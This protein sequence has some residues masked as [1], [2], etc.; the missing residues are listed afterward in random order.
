MTSDTSNDA[1]PVAAAGLEEAAAPFDAERVAALGMTA[2]GAGP[3]GA[4]RDARRGI[5]DRLRRGCGP[6]LGLSWMSAAER[7]GAETEAGQL[8][9]CF[10]QS[11]ALIAMV[12]GEAHRLAI[13]NPR[14][15][16][17]FGDRPWRDRP[18]AEL[19]PELARNG[20]I[21]AYDR[22]YETGAGEILP[23]IPLAGEVAGE[24]RYFT[25]LLQPRRDDAGRVTGVITLAF[26][27]TE[28]V[29]ARRRAEA[30]AIDQSLQQTS[31]DLA[32]AVGGMGYVAIDLAARRIDGGPLL[33]RLLGAPDKSGGWPLDSLLRALED[34]DAGRLR[35]MLETVQDGA[36]P[37][38]AELSLADHE[39]VVA[40]RLVGRLQRTPA[41]VLIGIVADITERRRS[42][43]LLNRRAADLAAAN[44]QLEQFT[45]LVS[46]DLKSPLRGVHHLA[47]F[48]REDL[49][50]SASP[51][52][53]GHLD[54][55]ERQIAKMSR[56]L[57]DLQAY[58]HADRAAGR[59][60]MVDIGALV[61]ELAELLGVPDTIRLEVDATP[62]RVTTDRT[63]LALVLRNLI[64]NAVKHHDR[65]NG[66]IAVRARRDGR[67]RLRVVVIDDG[68]GIAAK[69]RDAVFE[70]FRSAGGKGAGSGM[71]LAFVR[72]AVLRHGGRIWIEDAPDGFAEPG[73]GVAFT[74]TWPLPLE[75]SGGRRAK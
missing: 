57:D 73:R 14:M 21:A 75:R 38:D 11:P 26:D 5:L 74:F 71:G 8:R 60:E 7:E 1:R 54:R 69:Q 32:F 68:P 4:P 18:L 41:A 40:I 24:L 55:L 53:L 72:R 13:A 2:G 59:G 35:N 22:V 6:D 9:A 15:K 12:E 16:A 23:E 19:C 36:T 65:E 25:T 20:A 64:D 56:M 33:E 67:A 52:V 29:R 43:D 37:I 39:D 48:L 44:R 66:R 42:E 47:S 49:G 17:L 62:S 58:A 34:G 28:L 10:E 27:T 3:G 70:L 63:A 50:A 31:L 51:A 45:H 30:L 61:V 46:H